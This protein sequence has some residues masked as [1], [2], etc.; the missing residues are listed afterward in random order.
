MSRRDCGSSK[1]AYCRFPFLGGT[2][3]GHADGSSSSNDLVFVVSIIIATPATVHVR[4]L[5]SA[6]E[7]LPSVDQRIV[8]SDSKCGISAVPKVLSKSDAV[9]SRSSRVSPTLACSGSGEQGGNSA[10]LNSGVQVTSRP[11]FGRVWTR[12]SREGISTYQYLRQN[13]ARHV[14]VFL[15]IASYLGPTHFPSTKPKGRSAPHPDP[16]SFFF[17]VC[18]LAA[19][20]G[21]SSIWQTLYWD[22]YSVLRGPKP[23]CCLSSMPS[24][25]KVAGG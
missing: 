22:F 15:A 20:F 7:H 6:L 11:N 24:L 3:A 21:S 12:S 25:S 18:D 5:T 9:R 8:R 13:E 10:G 16:S 19:H 2:L 23:A 1:H 14:A 17:C 4:S